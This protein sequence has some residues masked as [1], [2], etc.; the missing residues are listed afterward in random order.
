MYFLFTGLR[1]IGFIIALIS[2]VAGVAA[3]LDVITR[4][5]AA[6]VAADKQSKI[7]W[8]M[9]LILGTAIG[10]IGLIAAIVYF[11]DVRPA[12]QAVG[13]GSGHGPKSSSDGP[14]GPS[15]R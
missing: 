3:L 2:T 7:F 12:L 9:A 13:G 8:L 1:G 10:F 5:D 11:I 15:R 6:F 14:Y 4:K